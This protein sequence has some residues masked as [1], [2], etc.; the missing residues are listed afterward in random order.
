MR[1]DGV[2]WLLD[3]IGAN[4]MNSKRNFGWEFFRK[5]LTFFALLLA[6]SGIATSASA[7]VGFSKSFSPNTVGPNSTA[8]LIFTID[9]S[10]GGTSA[11][12]LNFTD[13][14]PAT[15]GAM[16]IA[17]PANAVTT[18][19]GGVLSAPS[20][21]TSISYSAGS[22]GA[23]SSCTISVDVTTDATGTYTN[24]SGDLTSSTGNSGTANADLNVVA[25]LPGFSKSFSPSTVSFGSPSTLTYVIDNSANTQNIGNLDFSESFATG[26]EIATP[27]NAST[28]CIGNFN[29]T[30]LTAPEGGTT[31]TLDANGANFSGFQVLDAGAS[32]TVTVDV[33][34]QAVGA[35]TTTSDDLLVDFTRAGTA[36]A[37]LNVTTTPL[38]LTKSFTTD[39]AT[40]GGTVDLEFTIRNQNRSQQATNISFTDDLDAVLSGLT[41]TTMPSSNICGAG[42]TLSGTNVLTLA[43][44][45]LG[46]GASCTFS[47]TLQIP[48]GASTGTYRNSTSSVTA[49]I[50]GN[51][52]TGA[53]AADN[54]RIEADLPSFTKS[55]TNDPVGTGSTVS[56][57]YTISNT[58][59]GSALTNLSFRD[60]FS[61]LPAP[62][63]F[64][65]NTTDV[66]G[67]GS[68]LNLN[69][70]SNTSGGFGNPGFITLSGGNLASSTFCTFTVDITIPD[71]VPG[72]TYSST[73]G[74]L[75]GASGGSN[76]SGP[77]AS[78]NLQVTDG[79]SVLF[80][81]EFIDDPVS[82]GDAVTLEFTITNPSESTATL[83]SLAFTDDLNA[84]LPGLTA[85]GLPLSNVC[86]AGSMISGT[87]N[88]SFSG[89][90]LASGE[91]CNF[92]VSTQV[93]AAANPGTYTNT[94]SNLTGSAS[95]TSF[96]T[97]G[98]S[99][100]L[101][102]SG[103]EFSKEFSDDPVS[104]GED[105][106][107][108]YTIANTGSSDA[109]I[110]FFSDNLNSTLSGLSASGGALTN[111]CG[112]TLSGTSN[113][114]YSGGSLM[115]GN[116]CEIETLVSVPSGAAPGTYASS[117]SNLSANYGGNAI[118]VPPASDALSIESATANVILSKDFPDGSVE[119]G[120]TT[121]LEFTIENSGTLTATNINF[122]DDLDAMLSGAQLSATNSN[123]CNATI[124]G[125]SLINISNI[126][127]AATS[128]CTI[129]VDISVP[130]GAT[131]GTYANTTSN[132]F[133]TVNGVSA[134]LNT[135]SADLVVTAGS[136]TFT[137]AFTA[138]GGPGGTTSLEF[139]ITNTSSGALSNLR[140]TD[141]L[142]AALPGLVASGLPTNNICGTGSQISG[143]SNLTFSGGNLGVGESCNFSV[144]IDIPGSA[145]PGSYAN[146]TTNLVSGVS[147]I[148]PPATANLEIE[149]PPSFAKVFAPNPVS[150][151]TPS[152]LTFTI[153][154]S[155]SALSATSLDFTDNLPAGLIIAT[156]PNV[157]TTCIG[158][159]LTAVAGSG[160]FSYS[161]GSVAA[162][163]SCTAT[164]DTV[165]S[166]PA[167]YTNVSGNLT[168]SSGNSGTASDTLTVNAAA[169]LS[170][171]LTD[172][173]D[174]ANVGSSLT[175]TAEIENLGPSAATSVVATT[176]LPAGVTF[177]S[178][179]GC[180][181]DPT[182]VPTCSL[183]TIASGNTAS[184]T[185]N[186]TIDPGTSGTLTNNVSITSA[187]PDGIAA[188][189]SA[190]ENTIVNRLPTA[191]AGPDQTAIAEA[192]VVTLDGSGSSDPDGTPL[193][194]AWTQTSGTAVTLSDASA[195]SPTFT[196][197]TLSSNTDETLTFSLTV[198]DGTADSAAD[199]VD[200]IITNVNSAPVADAGPDQ[201]AVAEGSTITLDGSGSSDADGDTL[202]YAWAQTDGITV[203][204]SDPSAVSP[205]FTAPALSSNA[206]ETLTFSLIV[207]D[208]TTNSTADMVDITVSN[209]NV[210]PVA[211]AGPDQPSVSEG[212]TVSLDGSASSDPDADILT[213]AWSQTSGRSVTLSD[214][215]AVSP[216]FTAPEL[217]SNTSETLTFS[218]IV[219]DGSVDSL[220]DT[221]DITIT[222]VNSAPIADAGPDQTN[223]TEETV[224][225]L[226]G[227]ASTDSDA[228]TLT[229]IWTQTSGTNV[230]LSDATSVSP[231][232]TAP[233][234]NSS[235]PETLTFSLIVND[236]TLD[237]AADAVSVTITNVNEMPIAEAGPNQ[238]DVIE[239]SSVTLNGS[240]SFDPDGDAL[241]YS[242]TQTAGTNVTLSDASAVS[243]S[244]TAPTLDSNTPESLTFSLIVNDGTVDSAADTVEVT[245]ANVNGT[246]L[247]DAGPDQTA[248]IEN[249]SITLDGSASSDPDGDTLTYSWTQTAGT[250]VTLSDASA[251]SPSFTAP[252]LDSNTPE[253]LTFSLIVNDGT[254]DSVADT[255]DVIV[256]NVNK[257]PVANAGSDQSDIIHGTTVILNAENSSDPDGDELSFRW[258]QS[259]GPIVTLSDTT[260]I[261]PSFTA[262]DLQETTIL[263]FNLVANDGQVDSETDQVDI[264]VLENAPP[265]LTI[266]GV[267]ETIDGPFTVTFNFSEE[268]IGFTLEDI[269]V[270]NGTASNLQN[271]SGGNGAAK[272]GEPK[273][274]TMETPSIYTAL[275]SPVGE[276]RLT[277]TVSAGVLT[278]M[279]G[280]PIE[281]TTVAA[282]V[283]DTTSPSV[284]IAAL[285]EEVRGPFTIQVNFSEAV[286]GF[287]ANDLTLDN[288]SASE[289]ISLNAQSY[290]VLITPLIQGTVSIDINANVAQDGAGNGNTA[291]DTATTEFIDEDFVRTRTMAAISNFL[292]RRADQ[293]TLNDPDLAFR[294]LN[295]RTE[296]KIT[297]SADDNRAQV[298]FNASASGEDANLYKIVGADAAARINLWTEVNFSRLK[299][300]TAQNSMAL[301]FAGIDYR[302][303]EKTILGFMGQYD[304]A[305]EE[306][307]RED[308]SVS[309]QGWMVGPYIV[310]RLTDN[311]V[312]DGRGAWGQSDNDI[313]PFRT[314]TDEFE[315]DRWLLKGQ[316]TGDF[317]I[318]A[319]KIYPSLAVIYFEENQQAY[320]DSLDIEIGSQK[321]KL[322]RATFGP[323]IS[324]TFAYNEKVSFIP[325]LSVRG[326][327]DFTR[328]DILN[329]NTGFAS[330]TDK[331]RARTEAGFTALFES[332][333]SLRLD[334][335]YDGIGAESFEAYGVKIN[336]SFELD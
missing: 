142:N 240:G 134:P 195:V 110:S 122:L 251:V 121:T 87:T 52:S 168:S 77:T 35:L 101:V 11:T 18:C 90:S 181:E 80:T 184:F 23:G 303:N 308:V 143:T 313:S 74:T 193:T 55:F 197:P 132:G 72:G 217:N 300:E 95:G 266:S 37:T 16:T 123:S 141:D 30:V 274:E 221:V 41:A 291:A 89:G 218:L 188:N 191:N 285:P 334:G 33:I 98:A 279:A 253:T 60:E 222:N 105:V 24:I 118:T 270:T 119:P 232:F 78:D 65:G 333:T 42:S 289:F 73:S 84:V 107:L 61:F 28:S 249:T 70:G 162:G 233:A 216:T 203:T 179:S 332:G 104:P 17:T 12:S 128:V 148:S 79:G 15:P 295:S 144:I 329:I 294:L 13:N 301:A 227:S 215:S 280:N 220:A 235:A 106:T 46:P 34:G 194:Y 244:F 278:D 318:D 226:D 207:N 175:Y 287:T 315:T 97:T 151:S 26:I 257:A 223:V 273:Q 198:N 67:S 147:V 245:V 328:T 133:A 267:P 292:I 272:S 319:W 76:F 324:K 68:S 325:N 330:E 316:F 263:T 115:A 125:T 21:G 213:Y 254:V 117:S 20:G 305:D 153:D 112:G 225:T 22:L 281:A 166:A 14:L 252:T 2:S 66:C 176:A 229:Y 126:T 290:S 158:G 163:A 185:I 1:A 64:A 155:A 258:T 335:F 323:R 161:G 205:T 45:S 238:S 277:I 96:S 321:V 59:G 91:S 322:G 177:V 306:D 146:T 234:L 54:L 296:G 32:C 92:S 311:L 83:T 268:V 265:T 209:Q 6:A 111:T 230:A 264:I 82:S 173:N 137:K 186:V 156:P 302:L 94:T 190:S 180:A 81:K 43:G 102:V 124:S 51:P 145:S 159:T 214:A 255:V 293:I 246:P 154:N 201:P 138:P 140:F 276:G 160:V 157:S 9:N 3:A 27:S 136:A 299:S 239:T 170:I 47:A 247:A 127:L 75:S 39:P 129:N 8:K 271:T 312:F 192:T 283:I 40:P 211:N 114:T 62:I 297:G 139:T 131:P 326:I 130:S 183:G 282:T 113:L 116:S 48:S 38:L 150:V 99:N 29:D 286:T 310:S 53:P 208:G 171:T 288:A 5:S 304:W 219:N 152:T 85:T 149:V 58:S 236:G 210:M 331:L 314:Y 212:A 202:T 275:I 57:E 56:L 71:D 172:G 228:D 88:L 25:T 4:K 224:V 336:V 317:D 19:S 109:T 260:A 86:G 63:T 200:I 187:V 261:S 174:P 237:S 69:S 250:N 248:V 262:P 256:T 231:S 284:S 204:L 165:A 167:S 327:W 10:T 36:T 242:W 44:G 31:I 49:S 196:A 108:R 298:N 309:G 93:P 7:Q 241:T 164:V 189:N 50:G 206:S 135:A 182:G 320:T 178:T 243:P 169:D 269:T 120:Q 100:D 307:D 199:S 103:L 259:A